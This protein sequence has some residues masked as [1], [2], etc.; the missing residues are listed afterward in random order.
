MF[1]YCS[2]KMA[3]THTKSMAIAYL[4]CGTYS[5]FCFFDSN[6]LLIF[7]LGFKWINLMVMSI[8]V[9]YLYSILMFCGCFWVCTV[10]NDQGMQ[11][12]IAFSF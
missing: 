3:I 6:N 8:C 12:H 9:Y 1:T 5:L 10:I 11:I 2:T 4:E 7:M